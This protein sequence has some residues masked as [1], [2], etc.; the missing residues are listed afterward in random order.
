MTVDTERIATVAKTLGEP[1]RVRI[2]DVLRRSEQPVCQCELIALFGIRQPLL[3]HHMKKLTDAG[4][5]SVQRR[6]RWAYYS[7]TPDAFQELTRWLS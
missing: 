5:V 4:L 7:I 1:L 2:L 6:H 3:S